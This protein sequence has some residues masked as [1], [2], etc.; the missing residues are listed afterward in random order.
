MLPCTIK[1][2]PSI[3]MLIFCLFWMASFCQAQRTPTISYITPSI[4]TKIG[5]TIEMDCSVLYASEYPILG[6]KLPSQSFDLSSPMGH[7]HINPH[8]H[9][10]IACAS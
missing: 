2:L 5:G 3:K 10:I 6:V 1:E 7:P 9:E 4:T 8:G